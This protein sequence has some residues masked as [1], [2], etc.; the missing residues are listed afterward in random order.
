MLFIHGVDHWHPDTVIDNAFLTDLGIGTDATW[1]ER[2]V[3]IRTR[4]TVLPLEYIRSS[5]NRDPRQAEAV[6]AWKEPQAAALAAAGAVRKAGLNPDDIGLIVSG[7]CGSA[8]TSPALACRIAAALGVSVPCL[9]ISSACSSFVVQLDVLSRLHPHDAARFI[10]LASAEHLTRSVDYTDRSTAVLF[11]DAATAMVVSPRAESRAWVAETFVETLPRLCEEVVI[12]AGGHF[13]QNG[14]LIQATAITQSVAAIR[15]AAPAAGE[16]PY[17]IGHQANLAMLQQICKLGDIP[18]ER[19][20]YNVDRFG[21]CGTAGTASVLS[22]HWDRFAGGD[23]VI[24][25]Q[26]GAGITSATAVV[27]FQS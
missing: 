10:L 16:S 3:G 12:P 15:R 26:V 13:R 27:K 7:G 23:A 2:V 19:H 5:R 18:P 24:L 14:R 21:N 9:D 6:A 20:L 4:R 17:F 1:I 25:N 11:G 22:Q 8:A